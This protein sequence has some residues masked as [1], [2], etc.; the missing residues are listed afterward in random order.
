MNN[1]DA[2]SLIKAGRQVATP[3]Q[4]S[5]TRADG[6]P[7]QLT[8][9]NVLRLLPGKRIVA[10][11]QTQSENQTQTFLIKVFVGNSARRNI[12]REIAGVQA[13]EDSGVPTPAVEWHGRL[14]SKGGYVLAFEYIDG[15]QNFS[16]AWQDAA[17]TGSRAALL[18]KVIPVM[19]GLHEAGVIQ[20]DIHPEN[21][22]LR[23]DL[24]YTID[25][26]D[27]SHNRNR[28]LSETASL[29]NLALLFAQFDAQH[30]HLIEAFFVVYCRTRA[31]S[32]QPGH[33]KRLRHLV[34]DIRKRRKTNY[35]NKAFRECTRFACRKSFFR[36]S[37][38]D[39]R[40]HSSDMMSLLS[41]LDSAID[42]GRTLKDGNTATVA[43]IEGPSGPLVVKRYN[44]KNFWHRVSRLFRRSRGWISWANAHRLDFLGISTVRPVALVE[45]RIG[46]LRGRAYFVTEYVEAPD[47]SALLEKEDPSADIISIAD[48]LKRLSAAGVTHGD[49]K[50]SN[51]LLA[52]HGAVIIDLDS[53]REHHDPESKR[54]AE[55]KDL[56]RFMRNWEQVPG[57]GRRFADLLG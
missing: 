18:E 30:D 20:H 9:Q 32:L 44:L 57:V 55:Q 56:A 31:W 46:P 23:D 3:F 48:L 7:V 34:D 25:G 54:K 29:E 14:Q 12:R 1:L 36:F 42:A 19:V 47:A 43:L 27:V 28:P 41:D 13:I 17:S 24:V 40:Y 5:V 51:F 6:E 15:A 35:I 33:L 37:V 2:D 11:A 26:G 4:L 16:D 21:F 52:T 10:L 50:A 8:V 45:E 38:C 49:L 53:M 39:R 22:L